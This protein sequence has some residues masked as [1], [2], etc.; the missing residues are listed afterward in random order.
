[1]PMGAFKFRGAYNRVSTLTPAQLAGGV[2][3]S[4]SGN[5]AQ[6]LALAARLCGSH[7]VILMPSDAPASKVAATRGYGGEVVPYERFRDD[8]EAMT[9]ALAAERGL[10]VVHPYN[11]PLIIAGAGTTALELI[12]DSGGLD[13]LVVCLGGGGLLAGC[14]TAAKALLPG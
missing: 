4:S 6:A 2:V 1:Q 8:R 14:A 11:D 7:A 10:T 12:E 13:V 5:H 9:R 3:A